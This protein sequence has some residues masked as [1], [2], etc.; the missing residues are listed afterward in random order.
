MRFVELG[1]KVLSAWNISRDKRKAYDNQ[2][3]FIRRVKRNLE[4]LRVRFVNLVVVTAVTASEPSQA[5]LSCITQD[6]TLL[7]GNV[8][9]IEL[10]F[11]VQGA[12]IDQFAH[13]GS[14]DGEVGRLLFVVIGLRR[15]IQQTNS[16]FHNPHSL[17]KP[18]TSY[19]RS[20][21]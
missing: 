19:R 7:E 3:P 13:A 14:V 21:D 1:K 9:L 11:G 12:D 5:C 4:D 8:S 20:R 16:L 15:M 18:R 2:S 6:L 10:D 17:G